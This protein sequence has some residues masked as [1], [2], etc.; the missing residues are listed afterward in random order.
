[1]SRAFPQRLLARLRCLLGRH[2][3]EVCVCRVCSHTRHQ[4]QYVIELEAIGGPIAN[5]LDE[6]EYY[7]QRCTRCG[8]WKP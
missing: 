3:W 4:W 7:R 8:M 6:I 2:E 1:M 5:F